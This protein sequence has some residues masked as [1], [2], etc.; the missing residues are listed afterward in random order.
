MFQRNN[1]MSK[2]ECRDSFHLYNNK[3][4]ITGEIPL[5]L[6][7]KVAKLLSSKLYTQLSED[8]VSLIS[9]FLTCIKYFQRIPA[10]NDVF[11]KKISQ[12]LSIKLIPSNQVIYNCGD[13]ATNV[14]IILRGS[15]SVQMPVSS[16]ISADEEVLFKEIYKLTE[17]KSFGE[18]AIFFNCERLI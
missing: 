15:V 16:K 14:Y 1:P 9:R 8:E 2:R 13:K 18:Y 11:I 4:S 6:I 12:A 17:G 5:N 10:I 7:K 3:S